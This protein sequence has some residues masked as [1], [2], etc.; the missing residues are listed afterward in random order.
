MSLPFPDEFKEEVDSLS[1][2]Q[3]RIH[4]MSEDMVGA[5]L[6]G[7]VR[8]EFSIH[9][10]ATLSQREIRDIDAKGNVTLRIC[11][12]I[13]R[14]YHHLAA[15]SA[16]VRLP[17]VKVKKAYKDRVRIAYSPELLYAIINNVTLEVGENGRQF[18][19]RLDYHSMKNQ[20]HTYGYGDSY[21]LGTRPELTE[22][23]TELKPT[24]L[25][26]VIPWN[27]N[28][29]AH[30][31]FPLLLI[32]PKSP[33]SM[34]MTPKLDMLDLLRMQY[35][36]DDAEWVDIHPDKKYLKMKVSEIPPPVCVA[37]YHTLHPN[38]YEHWD[39]SNTC[40]GSPDSFEY[41]FND[42]YWNNDPIIDEKE[43][44]IRSVSIGTG[45][46]MVVA[47]H[48]FASNLH[49]EEFH[50]YGDYSNEG[51]LPI[52]ISKLEHKG[53]EKFS[54]L[55]S[56]YY[57]RTVYQLYRLNPSPLINTI[58]FGRLRTDSR[59]VDTEA[60]FG[61]K[62]RLSLQ[63]L[64]PGKYRLIVRYLVRRCLVFIKDKSNR[65][66]RLKVDE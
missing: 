28:M 7:Y 39:A 47:I 63:V 19:M 20:H 17:A 8:T 64:V 18:K 57:T 24:E 54:K 37:D 12:S 34:I 16:Y 66:W 51:E 53:Q 52:T 45:N 10:A 31:G 36:T 62:D 56:S 22:W 30:A 27:W 61:S 5:L 26:D 65:C 23:R 38:D 33:V 44:E 6:P 46:L 29:P 4:G 25:S 32:D 3:E 55:P 49:S 13:D 41:Y 35:L 43:D 11:Y 14:K 40:E 60:T 58:F 15:I 2:Q 42:Y 9:T 48:A 21:G 59:F 50:N 1:S